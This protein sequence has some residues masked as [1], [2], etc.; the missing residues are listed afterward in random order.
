MQRTASLVTMLVL[1]SACATYEPLDPAFFQIDSG[2]LPATD[3]TLNIPGLGPCTDNPDRRLRL[4]SS[5]PLHVL[6][7]GCYGSSGNFRGLAQVL[8]F[9]GSCRMIRSSHAP[10]HAAAGWNQDASSDPGYQCKAR[11]QEC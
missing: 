7:H 9:H 2:R 8:A 10:I 3:I 4:N 5:Q 11:G 6:V 1:L